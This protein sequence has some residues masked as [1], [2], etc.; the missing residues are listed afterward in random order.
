MNGLLIY[1]Y[2]LDRSPPHIHVKHGG[3]EFAISIGD[4][5]VEG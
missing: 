4:R 1:I 5:I 2:A 3:E